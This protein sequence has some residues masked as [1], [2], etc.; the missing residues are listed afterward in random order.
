MFILN[1]FKRTINISWASVTSPVLPT[2]MCAAPSRNTWTWQTPQ[3][4]SKWT[5]WWGWDKRGRGLVFRVPGDW[6]DTLMA[7]F[8]YSG[9]GRVWPNTKAQTSS[10][11][12]HIRG[13]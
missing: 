3:R 13:H 9:S 5:M 10:I 12:L 2:E 8:V 11:V 7:L 1:N 4:P 6:W